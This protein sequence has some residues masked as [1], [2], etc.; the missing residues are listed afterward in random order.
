MPTTLPALPIDADAFR[1]AM[2]RFA[3]SVH[4]VTTDGAAG[5]RGVTATA[6]SAVSAA[7]ATLLVC[8][9]TSSAANERFEGNG[10]F[11]VNLLGL[12]AEGVARIFAGEGGLD[13]AERFASADWDI[14]VT[15]APVLRGCLAAFDCRLTDSRIVATHRIMIGEVVGVRLGEADASLVYR[16]RGYRSL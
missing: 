15:G 1:D 3:S 9:N 13:A 8:L 4:I 10:S 12:R 2:S 6:V 7:P 16:D 5:L 14:L 11:A